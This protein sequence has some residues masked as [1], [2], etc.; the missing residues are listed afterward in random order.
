VFLN[1]CL[2]R[3]PDLSQTSRHVRKSAM[4]GSRPASFNHTVDELVELKGHFDAKC[5][6]VVM[7]RRCSPFIS[8]GMELG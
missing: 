7:D 8:L 5:L 4:I 3:I 2:Q 6:P 1:V